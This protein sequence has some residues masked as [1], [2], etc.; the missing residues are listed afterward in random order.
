MNKA[1]AQIATRKTGKR[2]MYGPCRLHEARKGS[3]PVAGQYHHAD[4]NRTLFLA[5][6]AKQRSKGHSV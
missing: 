1:E 4:G 5:Q 3:R 2:A 6:L